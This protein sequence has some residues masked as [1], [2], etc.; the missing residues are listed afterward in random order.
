MSR[1]WG[2]GPQSAPRRALARPT[3]SA[4][5]ANSAR[6]Q[7]LAHQDDRLWRGDEQLLLRRD[8][9][10]LPALCTQLIGGLTGVLCAR[11]RLHGRRRRNPDGDACDPRDGAGHPH[12][13]RVRSRVGD[14]PPHRRIARR[15]V[16]LVC[17][18][19]MGRRE[20]CRSSWA[21][22][23]DQLL[24]RNGSRDGAP[25]RTRSVSA[26]IPPSAQGR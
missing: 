22:A 21:V 9:D 23:G 10:D 4:R 20:G 11:R 8:S 12:P 3:V 2:C 13:E 24:G 19:R 14:G 18:R 25:L 7:H 6:R 5:D 16:L 17:A 26:G 1:D 15:A